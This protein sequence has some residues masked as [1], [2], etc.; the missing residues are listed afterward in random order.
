MRLD[1][2]Q[3]ASNLQGLGNKGVVPLTLNITG[4]TLGAGNYSSIF[5]TTTPLTQADVGTLNQIRFSGVGS[6]VNN[7]WYHIVNNFS[8]T[9]TSPS[10]N[11]QAFVD[12]S[13]GS[14]RLRVQMFNPTGSNQSVPNIT[15]TLNTLLFSA[16]WN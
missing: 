4:F 5:T 13:S 7:K 16:P 15:I 12:R 1:L 3:A 8:F 2:I 10:Y 14:L 11:V 9:N 6:S